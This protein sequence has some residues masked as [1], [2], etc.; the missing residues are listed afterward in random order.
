MIPCFLRLVLLT[1]AAMGPRPFSDSASDPTVSIALPADVRSDTM[2][3][4]Y[5]LSG[6][7]GGY[8]SRLEPKHDVRR[9]EINTALKGK[10]ANSIRV[11]V[12]AP[13]CRFQTF[14]LALSDKRN[15][16]E[17]FVCEALPTIKLKGRIPVELLKDQN[18]EL[19]ALYTAFWAQEFF[20]IKD[21][22]LPRLPVSRAEPD[23]QGEFAMEIPDFLKDPHPISGEP[24]ESLWLVLRDSQ[25]L[26]PVAFNLEPE[27]PE[28]RTQTNQLRIAST[29]PQP[30]NFLPS[31]QTRP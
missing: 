1:L 13:G 30:M 5:F 6:P 25:T 23:D 7:F 15:L 24:S 9:Y 17:K 3:V 2:Q 11:L 19:I 10:P 29:Y 28:F 16:Q 4:H 21:G 27:R 20:G 26:N 22:S 14:V 18:A 12:Y 8:S 31:P